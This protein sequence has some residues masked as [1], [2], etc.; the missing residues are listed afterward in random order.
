[1]SSHTINHRDLT[2]DGFAALLAS[3]SDLSEVNVIFDGIGTARAQRTRPVS[4][5]AASTYNVRLDGAAVASGLSS[6]TKTELEA[7]VG[8]V[9]DPPTEL[10][11]I[12]SLEARVEVLENA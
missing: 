2:T 9:A 7:L 5:N 3:G 12:A 11:R 4:S 8:W 10:E 6:L 1:M